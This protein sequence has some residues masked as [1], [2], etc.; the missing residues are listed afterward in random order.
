MSRKVI[1]Y[2]YLRRE[3]Q[4]KKLNASDEKDILSYCDGVQHHSELT[5]HGHDRTTL[6][7]H[8]I[9]HQSLYIFL[10]ILRQVVNS[11]SLDATEFNKGCQRRETKATKLEVTLLCKILMTLTKKKSS[12]QIKRM[13]HEMIYLLLLCNVNISKK[14]LV[15]TKKDTAHQSEICVALELAY[16]LYIPDLYLAL[17]LNKNRPNTKNDQEDC[18]ETT[19][20]QCESDA[21]EE[22]IRKLWN[23]S[24]LNF[25]IDCDDA[26][27]CILSTALYYYH[28][29]CCDLFKALRDLCKMNFILNII[30]LERLDNKEAT[31]M[32][33]EWLNHW[34]PKRAGDLIHRIQTLS[35][36]KVQLNNCG[37]L[38]LCDAMQLNQKLI[39]HD[40][41]LDSN[42]F[43][44]SDVHD[45]H[46]SVD[47][48]LYTAQ[49]SDCKA[50][51]RIVRMN[52]VPS[53]DTD[54]SSAHR[55]PIVHG[56]DVP[57]CYIQIRSITREEHPTYDDEYITIQLNLAN[58]PSAQTTYYVYECNKKHA[59]ALATVHVKQDM[60]CYEINIDLI[61]FVDN[62]FDFRDINGTTHSFAVYRDKKRKQ[63]ISNVI[64]CRLPDICSDDGLAETA[65]AVSVISRD[66]IKAI[67]NH[68]DIHIYWDYPHNS[69]NYGDTNEIKYRINIVNSDDTQMTV[70]H[71]PLTVS[72]AMIPV[73]FQVTTL[74]F[75]N[76]ESYES[77]P[78][79]IIT[80][81]DDREAQPLK[82]SKEKPLVT[83]SDNHAV[84]P[85]ILTSV[86]NND[87]KNASTTST[88]ECIVDI[89]S[90]FTMEGTIKANN[91]KVASNVCNIHGA[92]ES[93]ML[94]I[95]VHKHIDFGSAHL[96]IKVANQFSVMLNDENTV[97]TND[98]NLTIQP[99]NDNEPPNLSI[100]S[101]DIMIHKCK[102]E[103]QGQFK[104]MQIP[105]CTLKSCVVD[106]H[107]VVLDTMDAIECTDHSQIRCSGMMEVQNVDQFK[108]LNA[109]ALSVTNRGCTMQ[110][111]SL[112]LLDAT[113]TMNCAYE[114]VQIHCDKDIRLNGPITIH[115]CCRF[116]LH[117]K[118]EIAIPQTCK[119]ICKSEFKH[120]E[121]NNDHAAIIKQYLHED[122]DGAFA[123][124]YYIHLNAKSKITFNGQMI[125]NKSLCIMHSDEA[126]QVLNHALFE[127]YHLQMDASTRIDFNGKFD[128]NNGICHFN[129]Q[130]LLYMH[131][132]CF[133][134]SDRTALHSQNTLMIRSGQMDCDELCIESIQCIINSDD[135]IPQE[136]QANTIHITCKN[137][138]KI[139]NKANILCKNR[140]N[141]DASSL[142]INHSKITGAN[143]SEITFNISNELNITDA[144]IESN[145]RVTLAHIK[146]LIVNGSTLSV[147]QLYLKAIESLVLGKGSVVQY[148]NTF[149]AC[150]I[151]HF[152]INGNS[153][154]SIHN[155]FDGNASNE[156]LIDTTDFS[157]DNT[158]TMDFVSQNVMIN[159]HNNIDLKGKVSIKE[160]CTVRMKANH[161]FTLHDTAAIHSYLS[162][163]K[164]DKTKLLFKAEHPFEPN[165]LSCD[166][167][168]EQLQK[169]YY[170]HLYCGNRLNI[171]GQVI[172]P[173]ALSI[174]DCMNDIHLSN[175]CKMNTGTLCIRSM[176]SITFKGKIYNE[177]GECFMAANHKLDL[178]QEG[179]IC[180][181][182]FE[183]WPKHPPPQC[184]ITA[185]NL[186]MQQ[187]DERLNKLK[188]NINSF[189]AIKANNSELQ[190][191][192]RKLIRAEKKYKRCV[193]EISDTIDKTGLSEENIGLFLRQLN[194]IR[195]AILK[196]PESL[197]KMNEKL[198]TFV[199]LMS[200]E[201]NTELSIESYFGFV[202]LKKYEPLM[203]E[204]GYNALEEL[205]CED[206]REF[207]ERIVS[208][209]AAVDGFNN[210]DRRALK[211][212]CLRPHVW[213]RY[214]DEKNKVITRQMAVTA[215]LLKDCFDSMDDAMQPIQM[216]TKKAL[217][218]STNK[219]SITALRKTN[220]SESLQKTAD[221]SLNRIAKFKKNKCKSYKGEEVLTLKALTV[222]KG[223][224][225]CC[226]EMIKTQQEVAHSILL[227][228]SILRLK[229][230][231]LKDRDKENKMSLEDR[232][233]ERVSSA[234]AKA[235]TPYI[236]RRS[237]RQKVKQMKRKKKRQNNH[238][239]R[240]PPH[241]VHIAKD[242]DTT[243]K[244]PLCFI[245]SVCVQ[246]QIGYK[247][248][249]EW[250]KVSIHCNP[251]KPLPRGTYYIYECANNKRKCLDSIRIKNTDID[252]E[253]TIDLIEFMEDSD[254][255]E[256]EEDDADN[257][258][259]KRHVIALYKDKKKKRMI[260][261]RI[262]VILPDI[263]NDAD[264]L[265]PI[266]TSSIQ[267]IQ[268]E[269]DNDNVYVYWDAPPKITVFGTIAYKIHWNK[270]KRD[271]GV[272]KPPFKI[273]VSDIPISI[274]I[275]TVISTKN[276]T[277]ESNPTH[278]ILIDYPHTQ[279]PSKSI[280]IT[281]KPE[282]H[283]RCKPLVKH[284]QSDTSAVKPLMVSDKNVQ[285]D[286]YRTAFEY[287]PS[288]SSGI[289]G[290]YVVTRAL[291]PHTTMYR[292]SFSSGVYGS[293]LFGCHVSDG[294][295]DVDR[296]EKECLDSLFDHLLRNNKNG[297]D[298]IHQ[299]KQWISEKQM[300]CAQITKD[301]LR[302]NTS[303]IQLFDPQMF[304][305]VAQFTKSKR[306]KTKQKEMMLI[307]TA[308]L[309]NVVDDGV[310]NIWCSDVVAI[311][312]AI[313]YFNFFAKF[314]KSFE[315]L[316][317]INPQQSTLQSATKKAKNWMR[318]MMAPV[319]GISNDNDRDCKMKNDQI[320]K[321]LQCVANTIGDFAEVRE[322]FSRTITELERFAMRCIKECIK[323]A[324]NNER[325]N[326]AQNEREQHQKE[327]EKLQ[328]SYDNKERQ[329][330][331][332]YDKWIALKL[333]LEARKTVVEYEQKQKQNQT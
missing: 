195:D 310:V 147:S 65:N 260:S 318:N 312:I 72:Q 274:Q 13:C 50:M 222:A 266:S 250:L 160:C 201:F 194:K 327:Y 106:L 46:M 271:I 112:F 161:T 148:L 326:R 76:G 186:T 43:E 117:A 207:N 325:F 136:I 71:L 245:H 189:A 34:N 3:I 39:I 170:L 98:S 193:E 86:S 227:I 89:K 176:H 121:S 171:L 329:L 108:I 82:F 144:L 7:Y 22:T 157:M 218:S 254:D 29:H 69:N 315:K 225:D 158:S 180:L 242:S 237:R 314:R 257:M 332:Q 279:H 24:T 67:A 261:N 270:Q 330:N 119:I 83:L 221:E 2:R 174:I 59:K 253:T 295:S 269:H 49:H 286:T 301:I 27:L 8:C 151:R 4:K 162:A 264:A 45:F 166:V 61:D 309:W 299:L 36:T 209:C 277:Y 323:E 220:P 331:K 262:E 239:I 255:D 25:I 115:E 153:A 252:H 54:I 188:H 168:D 173:N 6:L 58:A 38:M 302:P 276:S 127:L 75:I 26:A 118:R 243:S 321:E 232:V 99:Q 226:T 244:I 183:Y 130:Q 131:Q 77:E 179:D 31:D 143:E 200:R 164:E 41:L 235:W 21:L 281:A 44:M 275:T 172:A 219:R 100:Q 91:L 52:P 12:E 163:V 203:K 204:A 241:V 249:D 14:S 185:D 182:F 165:A 97:F 175:T 199:D 30:K 181:L 137:D 273:S 138:C 32:L 320:V 66:T 316:V 229:P 124:N 308:K 74:V 259:R 103:S 42:L 16:H 107:H 280:A 293:Y 120:D 214:Q 139:L 64:R 78:S 94:S 156:C 234:V 211:E 215:P 322:I 33:F 47:A 190:A 231:E 291:Q 128:N 56:E 28:R 95:G 129:S 53:I 233:K 224:A 305:Q 152:E 109:S 111:Q 19:T 10:C 55:I 210:R 85:N 328:K 184:S 80:V 247:M 35:L 169:E 17:T 23:G 79:E 18:K 40:L 110:L 5:E 9:K 187:L 216:A 258:N 256:D 37:V 60:M 11:A 90:C 287:K 206:E 48:E 132:T 278:M 213:K 285:I 251:L 324:P 51:D 113:S 149:N 217:M 146:S 205:I 304:A 145:H 73:S 134:H 63:T 238:D 268:Y 122:D 248:D 289:Y 317:Q 296:K 88:F 263:V 154:L 284:S 150:Q 123:A 104:M 155:D 228:K 230:S 96:F 198:S 283:S 84:V 116:E 290:S 81:Y 240:V 197:S 87:R 300:N 70:D 1:N 191:I 292:A 223:S 297:I 236:E 92:I 192:K 126:I 140:L 93:N 306:W 178:Q 68:D 282:K 101:T 57:R 135:S 333:K 177:H 294:L 133:I 62:A 307:R 272:D 142:K 196:Q 105:H 267:A 125:G 20:K 167:L 288:Y 141:I 212:I 313:K 208:I 15:D 102:I 303:E 311:E 202:N 159:A 114:Y 246:Q 319:V 298:A 265:R